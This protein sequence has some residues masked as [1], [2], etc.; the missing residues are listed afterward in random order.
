MAV[1]AWLKPA[2][3]KLQLNNLS[4]KIGVGLFETDSDFLILEAMFD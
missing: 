1:M 3:N 2:K 4:I